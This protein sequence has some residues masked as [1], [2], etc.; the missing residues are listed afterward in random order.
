[1]GGIA[2][3]MVDLNDVAAGI[4]R[5]QRQASYAGIDSE[6]IRRNDAPTPGLVLNAS[7]SSHLAQVVM[8]QSGEVDVVIADAI[9]G[10]VVL[11]E[12]R[13]I[14]SNLGLEDLLTTLQHWLDQEPKPPG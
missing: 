8:W 14:S 12:H 10:K 9:S 5:F 3:I 11:T 7:S 6:L 2:D 4:E 13:E 1:M